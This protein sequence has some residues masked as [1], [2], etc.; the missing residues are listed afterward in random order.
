[1]MNPATI[2][3]IPSALIGLSVGAAVALT[4]CWALRRSI[5]AL[6]ADCSHA[7]MIGHSFARIFLTAIALGSLSPF[8]A[9]S[10]VSALCAF[11]AVRN[12]VLSRQIRGCHIREHI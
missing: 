9:T 10:I 3:V 8:G 5:A 4:Y 6:L 11:V 7:R 12:L 2:G 1:M